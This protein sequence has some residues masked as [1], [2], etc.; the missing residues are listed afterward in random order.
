MFTPID[1]RF[2]NATQTIPV[3]RPP[4]GPELQPRVHG[5]RRPR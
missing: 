2:D 5:F 1:G 4:T 3:A